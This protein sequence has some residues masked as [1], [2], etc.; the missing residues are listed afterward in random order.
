MKHMKKIFTY[1]LGASIV[2]GLASCDKL[3]DSLEGDLTKMSATDLTATEAGLDRLMS[4]LYQSIP[5]G[6]FAENDKS[7]PNANETAGTG[8]AY[9]GGVS[10]S[11]NYQYVRDINFFIKSIDEA[12]E[13]E[14]ISDATY[15]DLLGE[16]KFIRAYYYFSSVR[17]YGGVPIVTEPLDDQFDGGENAGLYIPRSTEKAT[18]DFVLSELDEAANLLPETRGNN[19]YRATK[20]AALGLKSRVALWAAS[21]AKYWDKAG[22]G[23]NYKAVQEKLT[24][25]ASSDA[26]DY[27]RQAIAASEAIINSGKFALYGA[28]PKSVDEAIKNYDNLFQSRQPSEWIFGRSYNNGIATNSNGFDLKNSPNQ[29]HGSGTGVWKFGCYGV[30]LD[31]VDEFDNY[32]PG[33]TYADGKIKTVTDG[34]ENYAVALPAQEIGRNAIKALDLVKY[35]TMDGPFKNKDAR[36]QAFVIYPGIKF[37]GKDIIIQG[38]IWEPNG[39]G[40]K[41][42]E[43]KPDGSYE[44]KDPCDGTL[45]VYEDANPNVW[46]DEKTGYFGYGAINETYYSGFYYR[47]HTNDGSWYTTGFGIRKFL[48]P[49]EAVSESQNP[50]YDIRYAEILLNYCEAQVELNG[51]NAGE[52]KKYLNQ[53]RRRAFFQDQRDATIDNILHERRIELA[54]ENDYSRTLYRRRAFFNRE[55]DLADNPLGGRKHALMPIL[56]FENNETPRY[57]FVRTNH[58]EWDTDVR[59]TIANWA[60][61][62]YYTG[63]PNWNTTNNLTPNP[64]QE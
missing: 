9:S 34:N 51:T 33:N 44:L 2:L 52:S 32:G 21:E 56:V 24:Y 5:M 10:G 57:V 25:M 15:N 40:F 48:N 19:N 54:F 64:S 20:Y 17:V 60:P 37:R 31:L 28:E 36:F 62:S 30:T 8:S 55:R 27:Y 18:W 23:T 14:V 43:Q 29:I 45:H 41:H 4:T 46:M 63:I 39:V 58:Y 12:K 11:W 49:T 59:P 22:I 53:I 42:R 47:G 3:F 7:T 16:A 1:I 13:N 26:A 61:L 38:G 50:W 35:E 6:A